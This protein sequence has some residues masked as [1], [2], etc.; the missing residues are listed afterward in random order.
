MAELR[1]E[2]GDEHPLAETR[3][4]AVDVR[5]RCT[6]CKLT[7]FALR[8]G[9]FALVSLDWS[10]RSDGRSF[11]RIEV[12]AADG[13]PQLLAAHTV[14]HHGVAGGRRR[15]DESARG[16]SLR[17]DRAVGASAGRRLSQDE[18]TAVQPPGGA[19]AAR[20]A[21]DLDVL[22]GTWR[23]EGQDLGSGETFSGAV[24]REWLPGGY[25]LV[26]RTETD[27]HPGRG[28]VHLLRLGGGLAAVDALQRR[29]PRSVLLLRPGVVPTNLAGES[30]YTAITTRVGDPAG[31]IRQP[32]WSP[33][34]QERPDCRTLRCHG[35]IPQHRARHLLDARRD[36]WLRPVGGHAVGEA[37]SRTPAAS[38][39]RRW[40]R[41][42]TCPASTS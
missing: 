9:T 14:E 24:T 25:F 13:L 26:Q 15:R 8:D 12:S 29:G 35:G 1:R 32:G 23:L 11:P 37:R 7:C 40:R 31:P 30:G 3:R 18:Q 2:V 38:S 36:R 27:G 6:R 5:A 34:W 10:G 28:G 4:N 21:E 20:A 42:G 17:G 41:G 22:V 19:R 39:S 33:R 16:R